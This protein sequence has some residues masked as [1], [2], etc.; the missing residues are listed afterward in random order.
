MAFLNLMRNRLKP[1]EVNDVL[2]NDTVPP[3]SSSDVGKV[4]SVDNDGELEWRDES[5]VLPSVET[6]DEGKVLTVNSS[7]EWD[8]EDI[9]SQLPSVQSTDE[10]K[11]LTVNSSGEWVAQTISAGGVDYST[12]EQDTGVKWIDGRPI[13]QKTYTGTTASNQTVIDS[14]FA[15]EIINSELYVDDTAHTAGQ[16]EGAFPGN[17]N[18]GSAVHLSA[19][20]GLCI[21]IGNACVGGSYR[22]TIRYVKPAPEPTVTKKRKTTN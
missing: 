6:T 21:M 1:R 22:M 9:P 11:V 8:A 20:Q 19:T 12:S 14:D 3:R 17:T 18:W 13:Y 10:G 16:T 7:G 2:M 15:N 5:G 4:L